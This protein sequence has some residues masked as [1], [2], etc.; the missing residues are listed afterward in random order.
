[1]SSCAVFGHSDYYYE[2]NRVKIEK[3]LCG[4]IEDNGATDFFVGARG[5]FD[6]L[7]IEILRG[8]KREYPH[9]KIIRVWS[10]IPQ[11]KQKEEIDA[12]DGSVYL[13]ERRV[14][15]LHAII[16]TNKSMAR[17]ADYIFSGVVHDWGGAWAAVEYAKRQ[18]KRVIE[19]L[20]SY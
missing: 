4:L 10:Y 3:G 9:I 17:K 13:L 12:F 19:V 14:P 1:M 11:G 15:P 7:C 8:L 5:N 2:G 16:E 18:G 20:R 6:L